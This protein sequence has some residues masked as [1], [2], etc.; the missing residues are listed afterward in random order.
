MDVIVI[1][2]GPA[3]LTAAYEATKHNLHASV[4]EKDNDVGGI[5]KTINYK[6]YL[7]DTGGHR[8][9]TKYK[10]IDRIWN[11][12]LGD[13]FLKRPRLSRIYYNNKFFYYPLKPLNAL[14]NLGLITSLEVILSYL[15]SQVHPYKNVS[16]FE[17][18]V[19]NRFGKRLYDIFF[20]TYTEKVWGISCTEIQADW[21]AQ[22]IKGLSLS[23]AIL[24]SLG[25]IRR[26]QVTTL[27]DEFQYPRKGPGQMWNKAKDLI[28]KNGG[29]VRLNSRIIQL[30]RRNDKIVSI[31]VQANGTTEEVP[32]DYFLSTMPLRELVT[33]IH[34]VVPP[35][36]LQAANLLRYRDFFTVGLII[37]KPNIFPDNWIYIHSPD[38]KVARIQNYI[39]DN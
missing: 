20:K 5:S 14:M 38:I 31:L 39:K 33:A 28:E 19:S 18:W 37:D 27:I 32:G 34:P 11:E 7:F 22:R 16:N 25:F 3:G 12:I 17:E 23:K 8:F 15:Y 21:A 6:N 24:N 4:F 29:A 13:E 26:G 2:A 9:F 35:P 10:E 36:I 1:G 30:N